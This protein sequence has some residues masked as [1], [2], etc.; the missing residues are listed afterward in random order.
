M[1]FK[2]KWKGANIIISFYGNLIYQDFYDANNLIYGDAR[3]SLMEYQIADFSKIEKFEFTK[4]EIKII[5]TLEKSSSIWNN[6]VRLAIIT[7][8]EEYLRAIHPYLEAMKL[9]NWKIKI[10]ENI[11]EGEKWCIK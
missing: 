3:F 6:N 10:F 1:S 7:S 2:I 5:S 9:T 8:N 11:I 4:E